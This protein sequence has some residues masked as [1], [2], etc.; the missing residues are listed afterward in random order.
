M[1]NNY[2][3]SKFNIFIENNEGNFVFNPLTFA[4][5][6]LNN[7]VLHCL[8]S[9]DLIT[10]DKIEKNLIDGMERTGLI[11][12][13]SLNEL[14]YLRFKHLSVKY[15]KTVATLI[16]YPTLDCNF[17][18]PYCFEK[19]KGK[20]ISDE[21]LQRLKL[22]IDRRSNLLQ[23]LIIRWSGG[24]PLIVWDKIV[25]LS[26]SFIESCEKNKVNYRASIA[27]NG[28]LLTEK[29]AKDF[30][31]LKIRSAQITVDGP[32]Q[33]HNKRRIA[34]NNVNTFEKILEN[35]KIATQY[36]NVVIRVNID[37]DNVKHFSELLSI[38]QAEK[39]RKD[40][41]RLFCKPVVS[42]FKEPDLY[43]DKEFYQIESELLKIA[44]DYGFPFSFHPNMRGFLRCP[45]YQIGSFIICPEGKL[46]KCPLFIGDQKMAVGYIDEQGKAKLTNI[47]EY[48]K[49]FSYDPFNTKECKDCKILSLC[50]GKC[51]VLWEMRNRKEEEGCI[52][53]KYT[54]EK[55]LEYLIY[56]KN[57]INQFKET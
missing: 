33:I 32:P 11:V 41:V 52:P 40:R 54:I 29:I 2:K 5:V 47:P 6:K 36:I 23:S 13:S 43:A 49:S 45:Y 1:K 27:T 38:L 15:D 18:C 50:F 44:F 24:E 28:Y 48:L 46:Y 37:K 35:I 51:P 12:D 42:C 14:D 25:E 53:D 26:S 55:K 8:K 10:E 9:T 39:V 21:I 57:Q 22:Y 31:E 3:S 17:D 30:P 19:F 16:I 34:K 20:T 56:S 4:F 7:E